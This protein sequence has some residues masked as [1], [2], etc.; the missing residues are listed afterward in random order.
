[1][2]LRAL[3]RV[4]CCSSG[5][6]ATGTRC[7]DPLPG[8]PPLGAGRPPRGAGRSRRSGAGGPAGGPAG[9]PALVALSGPGGA[10]SLRLGQALTVC[11]SSPHP[12]HCS[13]APTSISVDHAAVPAGPSG[14]AGKLHRLH[15]QHLRGAGTCT[16]ILGGSG[17]NPPKR[18]PIAQNYL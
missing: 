5:T 10:G 6:G 13:A 3:G 14:E 18:A 2:R 12:K 16:D 17:S 7:G 15:R 4:P 9:A 1:M 11:P 8:R